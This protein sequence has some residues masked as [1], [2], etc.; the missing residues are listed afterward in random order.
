MPGGRT[1]ARS[2]Y[3]GTPTALATMTN[4]SDPQQAITRVLQAGGPST[5]KELLPLVYDELRRLARHRLAQEKPG[6]T[7]QATALV[8]EAWLRIGGGGEFAWDS[9]RHF[10]AA[11]A[12]AMRRILVERAR[13]GK[14]LR[15]GGGVERVELSDDDLAFEVPIEDVVA[16]DEAL[17]ALEA[18]DPRAREIVNLR[19]FTGLTNQETADVMGLSVATIERE[20]QFIRTFMQSALRAPP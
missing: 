9:R 19:F 18:T 6:Q 13:R 5:G 17:A 7:L 20:W 12:E 11:A 4:E 15:H 8:H 3:D 10:F 2:G 1:P 16:A 14:R